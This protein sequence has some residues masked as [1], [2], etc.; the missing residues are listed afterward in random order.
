MDI[1]L[2]DGTKA[3]VFAY[4]DKSDTREVTSGKNKLKIISF[5]GCKKLANKLWIVI[6]K[7]DFPCIPNADNHQQHI[8]LLT[9]N[10]SEKMVIVSGEA[11]KLNTGEIVT[12]KEGKPQ[13]SER[14]KI[15]S[16]YKSDMAFKRAYCKGILQLL[17]LYDFYSDS[18]AAE[19]VKPETAGS[20]DLW[21]EEG[22]NA[23]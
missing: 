4:I 3:D 12:N 14:K 8:R 10:Y 5:V 23:L 22:Y 21:G 6:S 7:A 13:H 2:S 18:E 15:D 1:T 9:M 16:K 17:E 19:F 20:I 11:S